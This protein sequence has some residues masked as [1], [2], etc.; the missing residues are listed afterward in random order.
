MHL[1]RQRFGPPDR[2]T[3]AVKAQP[4]RRGGPRQHLLHPDTG[5]GHITRHQHLGCPALL[6]GHLQV[7]VQDTR[8]RSHWPLRRP[9]RPIGAEVERGQPQA[10]Q[11]LARI[12]E[13]R[14]LT[15]RVKSAAIEPECQLWLGL[16]LPARCKVAQKRQADHQPVQPVRDA[17]RLVHKG[18]RSVGEH[19]VE[20][21]EAQRCTR[22]ARIG[23]DQAL[24]HVIGVMAPTPQVTQP[25]VRLLQGQRVHHRRQ[26]QQ[27]LQLGIH[28]QA[29]QRELRRRASG[30]G[31]GQTGELQLQRPGPE[32]HTVHGDGTPQK[33]TG[34]L[35]HLPLQQGRH[36]QPGQ[37]PEPQQPGHRP[38]QTP[39]PA[40]SSRDNEAFGWG[41]HG[42]H[43]VSVAEAR[44]MHRPH[45]A[46]E[47][48]NPDGLNPS[49]L[50]AG[51]LHLPSVLAAG[52]EMSRQPGSKRLLPLGPVV[53]RTVPPGNAHLPEDSSSLRQHAPRFKPVRPPVRWGIFIAQRWIISRQKTRDRTRKVVSSRQTVNPP[54]HGPRPH[55]RWRERSCRPI[56]PALIYLFNLSSNFLNIDLALAS[57]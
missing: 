40:T 56:K 23:A 2:H 18:E 32:H 24:Q 54:R 28:I 19:Q 15:G 27:R 16:H 37:Q 57:P 49:G 5:Q 9:V 4:V 29:C 41:R 17:R 11:G 39:P 55:K 43:G 31:H 22:R 44:A 45:G 52:E 30:I 46:P 38:C 48:R 21:R 53:R 36:G 8:L 50:T 1:P 42:W 3:Q 13:R 14:R 47:T 34:L 51:E 20:Q 12:S 26:P 10:Q 25:Q 35:L 7:H 33:G 6:E